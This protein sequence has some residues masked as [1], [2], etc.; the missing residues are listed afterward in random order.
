MKNETLRMCIVCRE[1]KDKRTLTRVVKNKQGEI[2]VDK[3]GKAGG[4]GAYVCSES[5][6]RAKL[7]KQKSLNKA[8]KC[9]ID[10]NIINQIEEEVFGKR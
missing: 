5:A 9:N 3:T 10:E 8:F 7:K 2:F 1:M 6:C 4:R